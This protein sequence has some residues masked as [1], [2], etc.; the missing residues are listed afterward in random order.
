MVPERAVKQVPCTVTR[1]VKETAVKQV[2]CTVTR[3]VKETAVKRVPVTTC[4]MVSEHLR[5][6]GARDDLPDGLRDPAV[7]RPGDDLPD[8]RR[9]LRQEGLRR[10]SAR[11]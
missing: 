2:P 11:R 10:R 1:M 5:Q 9:D 7:P 8:G 4:R 3:M 6:A